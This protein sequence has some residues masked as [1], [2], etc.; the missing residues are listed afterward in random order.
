M[1]TQLTIDEELLASHPLPSFAGDAHKASRGS[2]LI[3]AGAQ[4]LAGAAILASEAAL[5]AGAGRVT[6]ITDKSHAA[7]VSCHVPELAVYGLSLRR[8]ANAFLPQ[9]DTMPLK[10]FDAVLI[11]P[12]M[13]DEAKAGALAHALQKRFGSVSWVWDAAAMSCCT[14]NNSETLSA[15]RAVLHP[16]RSGILTPHAGEVAHLLGVSRKEVEADPLHFARALSITAGINVMLKGAETWLVTVDGN[17]YVHREENPGL[18]IS[19]SGDVLAGVLGGLLAQGA[20]ID[21]AAMWS[22]CV[23]A[24]AGKKLAS[25]VG[26]IGFL[27]REILPLIPPLLR[28]IE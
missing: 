23:H 26:E 13:K 16:N 15:N 21:V 19:G 27:P 5:R 17:A 12:G 8:D 6:V 14:E 10:D 20:A 11:G 2:L 7:Q 1:K 3:V 9:L 18:A 25:A 28:R 4:G 22:V 24:A